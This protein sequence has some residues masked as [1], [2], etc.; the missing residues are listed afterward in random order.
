MRIDLNTFDNM[1]GVVSSAH[2][3]LT[4]EQISLIVNQAHQLSHLHQ[5]G[6][7]I[8]HALDTLDETFASCDVTAQADIASG[9]SLNTSIDDLMQSA[10]I[11]GC[12]GDQVV[13]SLRALGNVRNAAKQSLIDHAAVEWKWVGG[14]NNVTA[15]AAVVDSQ[16]M[17]DVLALMTRATACGGQ[18]T[19]EEAMKQYPVEFCD[20]FS[21]LVEEEMQENRTARTST[22]TVV[23]V[24]NSD[25]ENI[26]VMLAPDGMTED[27]I[28]HTLRAA[29]QAD[30]NIY[31]LHT[32]LAGQGFSMAE[33]VVI[34][35]GERCDDTDDEQR[36]DV[37]K[38]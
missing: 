32:T 16:R 15:P 24:D 7:P 27:A 6:L 20:A 9:S 8:E 28:K 5:A 17:G 29:V 3:E 25:G 26:L 4:L 11:T 35:I 34:D 2:L 19:V 10:D 37:P 23:H 31:N 12:A 13:V 30:E 21:R 36:G 33:N 22:T 38:G 18:I 1:G 14:A